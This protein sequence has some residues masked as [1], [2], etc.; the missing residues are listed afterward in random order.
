M[1]AQKYARRTTLGPRDTFYQQHLWFLLAV[2][3]PDVSVGQY[4]PSLDDLIIWDQIGSRRSSTMCMTAHFLLQRPGLAHCGP[5]LNSSINYG[6]TAIS[7]DGS[8]SASASPM[9]ANGVWLDS[10]DSQHSWKLPT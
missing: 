7:H 9:P 5:R 2:A 4:D 10:P 3:L 6:R 8:A 1:A